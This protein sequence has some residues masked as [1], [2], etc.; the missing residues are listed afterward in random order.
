MWEVEVAT[1][2]REEGR[3]SPDGEREGPRPWGEG[4]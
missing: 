1:V 4:E 3:R 2:T